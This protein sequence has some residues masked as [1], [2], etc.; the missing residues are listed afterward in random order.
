M[1]MTN[2]LW[3]QTRD[4]LKNRLPPENFNRC[5]GPL[6]CNGDEGKLSLTAPNQYLCD[7]IRDDYLDLISEVAATVIGQSIDVC[8][9][10]TGQS[11]RNAAAQAE[12]GAN[13]RVS[14]DVPHKIKMPFGF[15]RLNAQF[16]M[17]NF[18]LGESNQF[19]RAA[20]LDIISNPIK[21]NPFFIYGESG[22]GKTHL[23]QAMGHAMLKRNPDANIV[24]VQADNYVRHLVN[25]FVKGNND[26]IEEFKNA[27]RS[28]DALLIDDAHLL[29]KTTSSQSEFL[30]IF[31]T[32]FELQKQIVVTCNQHYTVLNDF[33]A[34]LKSRFG[35]GVATPID[36][37]GFE[38]RVA[39]LKSK[40]E[41]EELDLPDDV[42]YFIAEKIKSNV[43]ALEGALKTL[44][45][46]HN[47]TRTPVSIETAETALSDLLKYH[48]QP[49]GIDSIVQATANY[50]SVRVS[51]II[52]KSKKKEIVKARQIAMTLA[53]DLTTSGLAEIGQFFG[54]RDHATVLYANKKISALMEK[55]SV[56]ANEYSTLRKMLTH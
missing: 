19:A 17:E 33:E 49:L 46:H 28:V 38:H 27:Y 1:I 7:E 53:R 40:A 15:G 26:A 42:V 43:R 35:Q 36:P 24:Y 51:E 31:N 20:A 12:S 47:F 34:G 9:E 45:A 44:K 6:K 37:P 50:Y 32:L 14:R 21:Y 16:T 18:V 4:S 3:R 30:N 48:S 25:L 29:S 5:I 8:V 22:N 13:N 11:A 39:I 2:T 10:V 23:M 52:G 55:D 41:T 56:I 54:N